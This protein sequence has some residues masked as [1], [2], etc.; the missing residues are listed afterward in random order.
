MSIENASTFA[1]LDDTL[2]RKGDDVSEGDDH[3][4]LIKDVIKIMFPGSL[5]QG[6]AVPILAVETD[7]N[8]CT[9]ITSNLQSQI[10]NLATGGSDIGGQVIINTADIL[11]LQTDLALG[12]DEIVDLWVA[13]NKNAA[14][15][16]SEGI[17]LDSLV[18][19]VADLQFEVAENTAKIGIINDTSI[20]GLQSQIDFLNFNLRAP[21][22]TNMI[23]AAGNIPAGWALLNINPTRMLQLTGVN[24]S[25]NGGSDDPI[26]DDQSGQWYPRYTN[27]VDAYK[28]NDAP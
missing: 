7:L 6:Y 18:G 5:G 2:P 1:Q 27:V 17:R 3:L 9:G 15:I 28:L 16:L 23:F 20:P 26:H 14:D 12:E 11:K 25:A 13:V 22:N 21:V 8:F 24:I 19:I 10:N 4:R